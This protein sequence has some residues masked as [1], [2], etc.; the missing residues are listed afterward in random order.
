MPILKEA[1]REKLLEEFRQGTSLLRLS[2][3]YGVSKQA[4]ASL[5][6]NREIGRAH[7]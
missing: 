5:A 4:V 3:K 1:Q 7:V 2:R 6:R